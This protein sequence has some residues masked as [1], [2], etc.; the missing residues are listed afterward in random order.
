MH[1]TI[2][3]TG[4]ATPYTYRL[5]DERGDFTARWHSKTG[6]EP[7]A[8]PAGREAMAFNVAVRRDPWTLIAGDRPRIALA[9]KPGTREL[10]PPWFIMGDLRIGVKAAGAIHWLDQAATIDTVYHAWGVEWSVDLAPQFPLRVEV[11]AFLADGRA[12][13][14]QVRVP[15]GAPAEAS[16]WLC[17]GGVCR[18]G[19]HRPEYFLPDIA[20]ETDNRLDLSEYCAVL[21]DPAVPLP[22]TVVC[23]AGAPRQLAADAGID[24]LC[25]AGFE[26][27]LGAE[28]I[29]VRLLAWAGEEPL[30]LETFAHYRDRAEDYPRQLLAPYEIATPEPS[31]NAAFYTA[32]VNLDAIRQGDGYLEG[33][34]NWSTFWAIN[35]QISAA[36]ALGRFDE[37]QRALRFAAGKKPGEVLFADGSPVD[38]FYGWQH[39]ALPYFVLQLHRYWWATGDDALVAELWPSLRQAFEEMLQRKDPAGSGFLTWHA[40]CNSF[41]Y[42][43][44]HLHLP[45]AGF[46]PSAMLACMYR[47]LAD[48][49]GQQEEERLSRQ[50]RRQAEH[51]ERELLRRFWL[52]AEGRFA[53]CLDPQGLV[54]TAAYYT[55]FVF[56]QL[57]TRLPAEQSWLSLRTMEH[58]LG[59]RG[60]LLRVGNFKPSAFGNDAVQPVQMCEAAEACFQAGEAERGL[61]LLR[62]SALCA[63]VH[64]ACPGSF[65]ERCDDEG[66]SQAP[67]IF[68]NSIG[69]YLQAVIGGLFGLHRAAAPQEIT[70][71]PAIP[72][73]WPAAHLRLG[74]LELAVTGLADEREYCLTHSHEQPA[75]FRLPLFGKP[76]VSILDGQSQ[77]VAF[78]RVASPGG[79][80][81][82]VRLE[83][84]RRHCLRVRLAGT[85]AVVSV[86]RVVAP[87]PVQWRLPGEGWSLRDPQGA[88]TQFRIDGD[89]LQGEIAPGEGRR[90]IFFVN[91]DGTR[92]S[93]CEW[94]LPDAPVPA[95]VPADGSAQPLDL[96][97][98]FNSDSLWQVGLHPTPIRFAPETWQADDGTRRLT[99]GTMDFTVGSEGLW[100][101]VVEAGHLDWETNR[102]LPSEFPDHLEL[103]VHGQV[104]AIQFLCVTTAKVRLTGMR[105]GQVR[106]RYADGFSIE[107]A[108]VYG[109]NI[110]L[111]RR[112]FASA[113]ERFPAGPSGS[114][115]A[116]AVPADPTRLL[117]ACTLEIVATDLQLGLISANVVESAP[118]R[119]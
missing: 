99:V 64:S 34:Q 60:D 42:Q 20:H 18:L 8:H 83:P 109:H 49:A 38:D 106:L 7:Q 36:V 66:R 92:E 22:V 79:D 58:S 48:M 100:L 76:E 50:W 74:E 65:G 12:L 35:Y 110:D 11:C 24:L 62:S 114:L 73:E 19:A 75:L 77:P 82:I 45:G 40:G 15:G 56:P 44:D 107:E 57:Y 2:D 111:S 72:Q 101:A 37:A 13:A 68:G 108:L 116:F 85:A 55:D 86:P 112:P 94:E 102:L 95:T 96:A 69:A 1:D 71:T 81:A 84:Q 88:F 31:I 59:H 90:T 93:V 14:V 47:C 26:R 16:L 17:Y 54:Q 30:R 118:S 70:W 117:G 46:S 91:C 27:T 39:D 87:G 63:T 10:D 9:T 52:P 3:I 103:P 98:L 28:P 4:Q 105:V 80:L 43:A 41:L 25:R 89:L 119:M 104:A 21:S 97:Q 23:D 61:R 33:V 78:E 32:V 115:F 51:L 67:Y 113:T 5:I 53:G 6:T 29:E